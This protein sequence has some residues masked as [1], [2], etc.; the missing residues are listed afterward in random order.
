VLFRSLRPL[1]RG[2]I[3]RVQCTQQTEPM[4]CRA[5]IKRPV[6]FEAYEVKVTK[7]RMGRFQLAPISTEG[8][9]E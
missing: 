2:G 6:R 7:D 8:G 3:V 4:L 9:A 5:G 1:V